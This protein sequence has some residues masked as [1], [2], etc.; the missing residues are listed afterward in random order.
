MTLKSWFGTESEIQYT[1]NDSDIEVTH[2]LP[3]GGD[4]IV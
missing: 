1:S 4:G 3:E 2:N